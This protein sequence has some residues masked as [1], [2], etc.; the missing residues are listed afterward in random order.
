[1]GIEQGLSLPEKVFDLFRKR[2]V[3]VVGNHNF[4]LCRSKLEAD[5]ALDWH[6]LRYRGPGLSDDDLFAPLQRVPVG[7]KNGFGLVD[8]DFNNISLA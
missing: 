8:I 3:E 5:S 4:A 6:T 1:V 7:E 2:I